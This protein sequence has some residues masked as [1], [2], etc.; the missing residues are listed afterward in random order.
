MTKIFDVL[1]VQIVDRQ[2]HVEIVAANCHLPF[3]LSRA[4]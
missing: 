2:R 1:A 4:A 3:L